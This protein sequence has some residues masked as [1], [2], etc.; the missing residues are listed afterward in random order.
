MA[1]FRIPIPVLAAACVLVSGGAFAQG[2][3]PEGRTASGQCVNA[4]LADAMR[5]GAMIYSQPKLSST[6]YP[7][8]PSDDWTVRYPNQLNA[9]PLL[10]S[11]T[12][13][14]QSRRG[15]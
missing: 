12:V 7:V 10:P 2:S 1:M 15:P 9:S 13:T 4:G 14:S 3:C 8:L 11:S 6:Q 5:Q